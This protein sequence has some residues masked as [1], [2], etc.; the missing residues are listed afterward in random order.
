MGSKQQYLSL[1]KHNPV[2][3][4]FCGDSHELFWGDKLLSDGIRIIDTEAN[5]PSREKAAD[6]I[7]YFIENTGA[8]Y[9][10]TPDRSKWI[11][12][13]YPP[14][15]VDLSE[16]Y[17]KHEV[18]AEIAAA[19]AGIELPDL[20]GFLKEIPEEYV[21][22]SELEAKGYLT[23]HQSLVGY[24]TEDF[25][26]EAVAEV[27]NKEVDLSDYYTM[28]EVDALIP[29]TSDF[30][31]KSEIPSVEGLAS[32]QFVTEAIGNIEFPETDLSGLATKDE[33]K[34]LA[35]IS[36][37]DEKIAAIPTPEIPEVPTKVSEL[38]NDAGYLT[39]H[40]SLAGYATEAFVANAIAEAELNDKDI[41]ISGLATKDDIKNLASEEYVDNKVASVV[42]PT[43]LSALE[44]DSNFVTMSDVE[45]KNYLTSV[46]AGYVTEEVL[47]DKGY[48]TSVPDAY[49]T[50]DELEDA[51]KNIEA[52]TVDL[53]GY[54]TE[55]WVAEQGFAKVS[56]IPSVDELVTSEELAEAIASIEHPPVD[57]SNFYTKAETSAAIKEAV[58]TIEIP[59]VEGLATE[60]YVNDKVAAIKIPE[61]VTKVSELENDLGYLTE[62]S[63]EPYAKKS[64]L[65]SLEGVASEEFVRESISA[66]EFPEPDMSSY[67]T[68]EEMNTAITNAAAFKANE[69][70][71]AVTQV[72]TKPVGAFQ[73]GDDVKGLTIAQIIAKL[74]GL[75]DNVEEPDEPEIPG[76]PQS[77]ADRIIANRTPMYAVTADGEL[78]EIAFNLITLTEAEGAQAPTESGFYQIKDAEGN[79]LESGY[80]EMQVES[81]DVYY[82]I[83][84]PKEV[85]LNSIVS[86]QAYS[87]A[88]NK[89]MEDDTIMTS[90]TTAVAALCDEAGIDISNI[91]TSKYT[92]WAIEECPT[93]RKLR[94]IINE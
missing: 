77:I 70:P 89:W 64:E 68:T 39:E 7:I 80:Q 10:L 65:P 42:V 11:Q 71:F 29:D 61:A 67:S 24:A 40:Q 15:D 14:K 84:M 49:V 19:I 75:S 13:I 18:A 45:A 55:S 66:I 82:V 59:S 33:V 90:D 93:G 81:E 73:S 3:L 76:T 54:A 87:T 2:A 8:G 25:V 41:D 1:A 56:D 85:D 46:P 78:A 38:E 57:L 4:Y 6:G 52:P 86:I 36:Y 72:V 44:N 83:A 22:E 60:S 35:S 23:E 28:S 31:T 74:L 30:A 47:E 48:L 63:L 5:L 32:E 51:I 69:I 94:F 17:T 27:A 91:D 20:T 92:V 58:D 53:D 79:V 9:V 88:F 21:T 12:V 43:K 34:D 62:Q 26:K 16:Y 37:V 50:Q